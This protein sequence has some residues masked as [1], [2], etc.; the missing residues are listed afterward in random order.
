MR[1]VKDFTT[2]FLSMEH[3]YISLA[4]FCIAKFLFQVGNADHSL[5][6]YSNLYPAQRYTNTH[7]NHIEKA[8]GYYTNDLSDHGSYTAERPGNNNIFR[9]TIDP[10]VSHAS[11]RI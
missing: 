6:Y 4:T 1:T 2:V 3:P 7:N 10:K 8:H 11:Y 9:P 5:L